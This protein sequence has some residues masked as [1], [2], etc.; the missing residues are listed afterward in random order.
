MGWNLPGKKSDFDTPPTTKLPA[1]SMQP[2]DEPQLIQRGG[3]QSMRYGVK[4]V[5]K[6]TNCFLELLKF[7][8]HAIR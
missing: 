3:M 4:I 2:G 8:I 1:H 5:A 7:L 6:L